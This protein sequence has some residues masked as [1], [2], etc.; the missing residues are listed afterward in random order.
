MDPD[1]QQHVESYKLHFQDSPA[2]RAPGVIEVQPI[3]SL[4][5]LSLCGLCSVGWQ[6]AGE[7]CGTLAEV[8]ASCQLFC[9]HLEA[10]H[11]A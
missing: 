11:V 7:V 10:G 9:G 3:R 8:A 5:K 6:H 2:A 1:E 4:M